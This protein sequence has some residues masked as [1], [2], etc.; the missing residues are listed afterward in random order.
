MTHGN[1]SLETT[2]AQHARFVRGIATALT[3]DHDVAHDAAMAALLAPLPTGVRDPRA[4]WRRVAQNA[5]RRLTRDRTRQRWHEGRT[6]PQPSAPPTAEVAEKHELIESVA[7]E[8]ARL[9]EP[10]RA[11]IL[12]R[13]YDGLSAREIA[14]RQQVPLATVR[15]R[16]QRG[17]AQLRDALDRR[18]RDREDWRPALAALARRPIPLTPASGLARRVLIGAAAAAAVTAPLLVWSGA[19]PTGPNADPLPS[20]TVLT[21]WA[22]FEGGDA[23]AARDGSPPAANPV[24]TVPAPPPRTAS[25]ST[26][27][28]VSPMPPR[29][30]FVH[31]VVLD[32]WGQPLPNAT[33][34]Q[35]T[36]DALRPGPV[37]DADGRFALAI[38]RSCAFAALHAQH[39]ASGRTNVEVFQTPL[40]HIPPSTAVTLQTRGDG[41]GVAGLIVDETG[42]GV[43]NATVQITPS[44]AGGDPGTPA[45]FEVRT[46][47]GGRFRLLGLARG[48]HR[49]TAIDTG[50]W[51]DV[52]LRPG[53]TA[54]V[55]L[56]LTAGVSIHGV[57]RDDNGA[58][59]PDAEVAVQLDRHHRTG[60][61]WTDEEGRFALEDVPAGRCLLVAIGPRGHRA[62]CWIDA[63]PGQAVEWQPTLGHGVI[64]RGHLRHPDGSPCDEVQ[65]RAH[66]EAAPEWRRTV[67]PAA[68]GSFAIPQCPGPV[69]LELWSGDAPGDW[70]LRSTGPLSPGDNP[71]LIEIDDRDWSAEVAGRITPASALGRRQLR[72][73]HALGQRSEH[74]QV[75]PETGE[76]AAAGFPPGSYRLVVTGE[77]WQWAPLAEVRLRNEEPADAGTLVLPQ[78]GTLVLDGAETARA[79]SLHRAEPDRLL[80]RGEGSIR[81]TVPPGRYRV[82]AGSGTAEIEV[83]ARGA[84]RLAV[85]R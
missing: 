64:L 52:Y 39:G 18:H 22:D 3:R 8:V 24:A 1:R 33:V 37:S 38:E 66:S 5:V 44:A 46:D 4:W 9:R 42:V 11:T 43:G 35:G 7:R 74:L 82:V 70:P 25:A 60:E 36:A 19:T 54:E 69:H 40:L 55:R 77:P 2:L 13:F 58:S 20:A 63:L 12:L 85:P 56:E 73:E 34:Y 79:W 48:Y 14:E 71:H 23:R 50:A 72:L 29:L 81:L 10:Y 62:E 59:V 17:T 47:S 61:T 27:P 31:G 21:E 45:A 83:G 49:V 76:F 16:V 26:E 28:P 30:T 84:H 51:T 15:S 80:L 78:D 41:V 75:D 32:P 67:E 57:V 65:I 68:D 6:A 53:A